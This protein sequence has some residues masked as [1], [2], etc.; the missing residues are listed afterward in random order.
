MSRANENKWIL[1][2]GI[3]TLKDNYCSGVIKVETRSRI[4]KLL[5]VEKGRQKNQRHTS[6]RSGAFACSLIPSSA[7]RTE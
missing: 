5:K 4:C 2:Q 1:L 6:Y 3:K 7:Q